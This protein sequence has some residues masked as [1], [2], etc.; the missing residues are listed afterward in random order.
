[1][2]HQQ[3]NKFLIV[4]YKFCEGHEY[5]VDI[6]DDRVGIFLSWYGLSNSYGTC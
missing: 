6:E 5:G 4:N 1:M 2:D 3:T